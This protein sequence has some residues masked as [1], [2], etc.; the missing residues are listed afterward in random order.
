MI[1]P[2]LAASK[3]ATRRGCSSM[4]ERLVPNQDTRVRF[5]SP[6]FGYFL[7]F[8]FSRTSALPDCSAFRTHSITGRF[9]GDTGFM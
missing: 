1:R 3:A 5:P 4:A 7:E 9:S 8:V 2:A 6:A